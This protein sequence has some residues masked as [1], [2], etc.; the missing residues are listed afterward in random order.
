MRILVVQE[1]DWLERGPHQ[2]HHLMERLVLRGHEVR[3]I[4]Y[5]VGWKEHRLEGLLSHRQIV[6][7]VHKVEGDGVTVVR[8]SFLRIPGL[9]YLSLLIT[10]RIEIERQIRE[11]KPDVIVGFGLLNA[12]MAIK[13]GK[14]HHIPF[15]YYILDELH[16]LVP[17][18]F[19]QPLA[20]YVERGNYERSVKVL[21]ISQGLR[22]YAIEMGASPVGT[23]ILRAGVDIR[24]FQSADG[25]EIRK[26]YGF[27]PEDTVLFFMGWLYDFSGLDVVAEELAR[28]DDKHLKLLVLGK[29]ELWDRLQSIQQK[30]GLGDRLVLEGW[31]PY[32]EVPSYLAA[33][34]ICLLPAKHSKIMENIVPIK[35]YEYLAAGKVV[36]STDLSGVRKEFGE[37]NGVLYINES[38]D[39]VALAQKLIENGHIHDEGRKGQLFVGDN[40]WAGLTSRFEQIL[41]DLSGEAGVPRSDQA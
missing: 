33:S 13:L 10:H 40:D 2:S 16:R 4:D 24:R 38:R 12:R 21:S 7:N 9:S 30:E 5:Q 28:S 22:D 14:K 23:E 17:E 26:K 1:S 3:V 19:L 41:Y 15:V 29:G 11:W 8:P 34:D 32:E 36:F 35:M 18:Q 20:K 31:K 6:H 39:V 37:G 27:T 25:S